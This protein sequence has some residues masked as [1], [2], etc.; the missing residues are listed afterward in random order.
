MD[1]ENVGDLLDHLREEGIQ[2]FSAKEEPTVRAYLYLLSRIYNNPNTSAEDKIVWANTIFNMHQLRQ[3]AQANEAQWNTLNAMP[4]VVDPKAIRDVVLDRITTM[5]S[6][7]DFPIEQ[8]KYH[9]QRFLDL[10]LFFQVAYDMSSL[11]FLDALVTAN[12]EF[13][14]ESYTIARGSK[15]RTDVLHSFARKTAS[16]TEGSVNQT[17]IDAYGKFHEFASWAIDKWALV[18]QPNMRKSGTL[19]NLLLLPLHP[20]P[21][22]VYTAQ[23]EQLIWLMDKGEKANFTILQRAAVQ[24]FPNGN[25]PIVEVI[26]SGADDSILEEIS[27][28]RDGSKSYTTIFH[29]ELIPTEVYKVIF[30]FAEQMGKKELINAHSLPS[31]MTPLMMDMERPVLE[32]LIAQGADLGALERYDYNVFTRQIIH[33]MHEPSKIA[34]FIDLLKIRFYP[35]AQQSKSAWRRALNKAQ[36]EL[37]I[38]VRNKE[39]KQN[40]V[41]FTA[42]IIGRYAFGKDFDV[43]ANEI[44][45]IFDALEF[46][47]MT[48]GRI[49][50]VNELINTCSAT[51][52]RS[53]I[54]VGSKQAVF[55][56]W[57]AAVI[58]KAVDFRSSI[59]SEYLE[60]PFI[61]TTS[62]GKAIVGKDMS[63][64]IRART[65]QIE[66]C[67]AIS[68]YDWPELIALARYVGL[69]VED[70]SDL[71]KSELCQN[72]SDV[73]SKGGN[74]G[75]TQSPTPTKSGA[76][77]LLLATENGDE[78]KVRRLLEMGVD[79]ND[80]AI[81][82][83]GRYAPK[84]SVAALSRAITE[85][86]DPA[87]ARLLIEYGADPL[88]SQTDGSPAFWYGFVQHQLADKY[89]ELVETLYYKDLSRAASSSLL[90]FRRDFLL[91]R[92]YYMLG[93][94][95]TLGNDPVAVIRTFLEQARQEGVQFDAQKV[96]DDDFYTLYDMAQEMGP[97][98]FENEP[99][100]P[101]NQSRTI[102]LLNEY[103][104]NKVTR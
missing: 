62:P 3:D 22:R 35:D 25:L 83:A 16:I 86:H 64:T 56:G 43:K 10:S 1:I 98:S 95:E 41:E 11:E 80:M 99:M 30:S 69:R 4:A 85:L 5:Q 94:P 88:V 15:E 42:G 55:R 27:T 38:N 48:G 96:A 78:S 12:P 36:D 19:L 14:T 39:D 28:R 93:N 29:T 37:N 101:E 102:E 26:L 23:N 31:K 7:G 61:A 47:I 75:A 45:P 44:G 17:I 33:A 52:Q 59:E 84:L 18:N 89:G 9:P 53:N 68:K 77:E 24:N 103:L 104:V 60:R 79:P 81:Y 70:L 58:N 90:D 92:L 71:R 40:S 63:R 54:G 20:F 46:A 72:I 6:E 57:C 74:R 91:G 32:Y 50:S 87:L 82:P 100:S 76:F 21:Q 8:E 73:L 51:R 65:R 34:P 67:T 66:L 97:E 49:K 2:F 13:V